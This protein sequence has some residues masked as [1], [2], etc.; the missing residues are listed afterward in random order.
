MPVRPDSRFASLPVLLRPGPDGREHE[1]IALRLTRP[2]LTEATRH[3]VLQGDMVD[4][5]ARRSNGDE[6]LWW[7][8]LDANPLVFP[9]DI[10]PGAELV[11]PAAGPATRVT[12][13]RSF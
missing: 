8:I 7:R 9:L 3:R 5:L 6:R 2:V 13:A 10:E 4:L 12:R 11:I 1:V